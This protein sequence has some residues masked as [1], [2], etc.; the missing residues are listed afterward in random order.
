MARKPKILLVED[1]KD[2]AETFVA[3]LKSRGYRPS[4]AHCG[5]TGR[6]LARITRP[7]LVILNHLMPGMLGLD[8]LRELRDHESTADMRVIMASGMQGIHEQAALAGANAAISY[9]CD[10]DELL[11]AVERVLAL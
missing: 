3:W 1:Q 6:A 7:D 4:L 2:V 11:E 10:R 5:L 9:P 8:L